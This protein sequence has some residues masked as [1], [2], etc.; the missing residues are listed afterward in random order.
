MKSIEGV[1]KMC[2]KTMKSQEINIK[3]NNPPFAQQNQ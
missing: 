3:N 1:F 2:K